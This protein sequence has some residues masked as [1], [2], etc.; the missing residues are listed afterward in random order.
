VGSELAGCVVDA[1][2]RRAGLFNAT[3]NVGTFIRGMEVVQEVHGHRSARGSRYH[4][5]IR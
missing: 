5:I 1:V 2:E 4:A 3:R